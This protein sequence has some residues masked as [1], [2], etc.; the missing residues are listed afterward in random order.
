MRVA[1]V[2]SDRDLLAFLQLALLSGRH[3]VH[4]FLFAT[5]A[6]AALRTTPFD[7]LLLDLGLPDIEG[8]EVARLAA[9][10]S[11]P[12]QIVLM[13]GEPS[14]LDR[15]RHLALTVLHKPFPVAD[16]L[17]LLESLRR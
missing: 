15:A 11:P 3:D 12:P 17:A 1:V 9:S 14:R 16:L 8:E 10:L 5:D 2:E 7:V 13:S 4:P 6:V